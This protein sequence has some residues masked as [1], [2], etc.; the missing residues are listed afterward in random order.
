M[1]SLFYGYADDSEEAQQMCLGNTDALLGEKLLTNRYFLTFML[2]PLR[3]H[4]KHQCP[5][6]S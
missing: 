4:S 6:R 2:E 5:E 1:Q 3:D